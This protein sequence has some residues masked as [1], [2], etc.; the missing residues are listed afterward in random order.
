MVLG[1]SLNTR[2][3]GLAALDDHL[4]V[5]YKVKLF[6]ERWTNDKLERIINCVDSSILDYSVK[7]VA[8]LLPPVHH[9]TPEA[10]ALL[11][12]IKACC[13]KNKLIVNCYR[14]GDLH[15]FCSDKRAKK[16]ALMQELSSRYPQLT[17]V[18]QKELKN[19]KRYYNKLFEAVGVATLLTQQTI[20]N[21]SK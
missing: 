7:S 17:F 2:I 6:K 3:V 15:S 12:R 13:R 11:Q 20:I 16:R 21:G 18:Q 9:R 5:D 19:K 1:I 14:P 4:L 10:R 8:L